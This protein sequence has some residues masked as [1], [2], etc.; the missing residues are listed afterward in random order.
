MGAGRGAAEATARPD[1]EPRRDGQGL[2]GARARDVRGRDAG[3]RRGAAG[4]GRRAQAA[5]AEGILSQ[6]L[7][8]LFAVA[9]AYPRAPRDGE[10][11]AAPGA[12]AE[13]EDKIAVARQVYNDTVLTYNN[14]IQ[15]FPDVRPRRPVRL[16]GA[17][18][19]RGRRTPR[20]RR[21]EVDFGTATG[22]SRCRRRPRRQPAR[23]CRRG[24]LRRRID[25][26]ALGMLLAG[27]RRRR[28]SRLSRRSRCRAPRA[29][30]FDLAAADVAVQVA[31]GRLARSSSEDI[32][33]AFS[34]P[35]TAATATSR[36]ARARRSTTSSVT[37][38]GQSRTREGR[39]ASSAAASARNLRGRASS[40]KACASSG[41]SPR[42]TRPARSRSRYTLRGVA[43]AYDDV[44]DVNLKV[45]GDQWDESLDRLVGIETAPG[46]D[47][48]GL[49][50][51]RVG[52]WRRR[53]HGHAGDPSGASTSPRTSSSS[54]ATLDPD[55]PRSRR[56]RACTSRPGNGA[57]R[58][59]SPRSAPTPP[60]YQRDQDRIDA[61]KAA[62]AA[63]RRLPRCSPR[64][65]SRRSSSSSRSSGSIGRER[66]DRLRPRVR[67]GAA[68]RHG[69]RPRPDA[70]APGRRG[71]VVRVHGD[72][73]RPDSPRRLQ[74]DA[75]RRPSA[76]IW[77]GLRHE[78]DLRPRALRRQATAQ[79]RAWERDVADVVDGVLDGG[80]ER[81]SRFRDEI[82]AEREA[83]S[84]RAS[85][86]SRSTS[87]R[88]GRA[89]R[90]V[91][92][93]SGALPLVARA[94]P[95]SSSPGRAR[96]L[97][98]VDRWRPVYPRWT[99]TSSCS[100]ES[101]S[102]SSRTPRSAWGRSSST[103]ALWRRR[104]ATGEEEAERWEAFRRYLTDFPR[105]Q[106]APP[107]TLALWER[108]LVYGIAF[109]IAERVLQA[110]QLRDARGAARRRARSTG[111]RPAATSAPGRR[112]SR[113]AT[114][115]RASARRSRRP[116]RR[117]RRRR[118][119]LRR[120]RRRRRWRRRRLRLEA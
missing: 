58:R 66:R 81:L 111:S 64:D 44:V 30:S 20:P 28:G 107:A 76:P 87:A 5:Q 63:H 46:Q 51:A 27:P 35:F 116:L 54:C 2:R 108:Y 102:A 84:R 74:G 119:L 34:A 73:L 12:A 31:A 94:R 17:R 120:R 61:L 49:G 57:R 92:L 25:R 115:P 11:P 13:T 48:A 43:V 33:V 41:T 37:E 47:R 21:A 53:A 117:E 109:G 18:V 9:E 89:T 110:A 85:R 23:A 29:H 96:L 70:P 100:S 8:R 99:R 97:R 83:M 42:A 98:G 65:A 77:G 59:S 71:R 16:H 22:A 72:A 105:L 78:S 10:L 36:C 6:A 60:T 69:A 88:R 86:R 26:L 50:Q 32:T 7:G 67:A 106:E 112:A 113:S 82:E 118:R 55:G 114:S 45:W 93:D 101:A 14:A 38:D 104:D 80:T 68:D 91:P 4:A 39:H 56:R 62:P 90:L 79:L 15:T 1:P 40:T 103:A 3:P 19:L 75:R 95:A 52:P 24:R